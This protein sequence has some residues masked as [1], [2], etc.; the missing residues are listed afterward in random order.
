MATV[1]SLP[2]LK[3]VAECA[4]FSLTVRPYIPQLLDLPRN[5]RAALAGDDKLHELRLLYLNTNPL[6]SAAA[7]ALALSVIVLVASEVNR[8]YSQVDR[9]WSIL[10]AV[11]IGHYAAWA[12]L[13]GLPTQKLDNIA[14]FGAVWSARL[15]FNY[16]RKGGYNIGSEDYRWPI[17]KDK[18][19]YWGMLALNVTFISFGQNILLLLITAPAYIFLLASRLGSDTMQLSDIVFSRALMGLILVEFF[20]DQQQWNYQEAKRKYRATAKLPADSK[21]TQEDL[22]RGF[23]VSGLWSWSRHPNFLAEQLI[24][25]TLYQWACYATDTYFN[26]TVVGVMGYLG[27][28]QGSTWLTELLSAQKYPEYEEYQRLV[29][30][31]FPKLFSTRASEELVLEKS[32]PTQAKKRGSKKD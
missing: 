12:H 13:N 6:A 5:L 16:W 7:L 31:F 22:D 25:V 11:Y 17:I 24:W 30:R 8:N 1:L 14:V 2:S 23:N 21:Y 32:K 20:A 26:W 18:L 28:F 15:T 19:G 3:S 27:V 10:P 4:D 29:G 9:L